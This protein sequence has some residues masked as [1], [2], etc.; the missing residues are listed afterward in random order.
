MH[1]KTVI[2]GI[3]ESEKHKIIQ[4]GSLVQP[5]AQSW[6]NLEKVIAIY[7]ISEQLLL[8]LLRVVEKAWGEKKKRVNLKV[9]RPLECICQNTDNICIFGN[10]YSWQ[11][12]IHFKAIGLDFCR[13]LP[14]E[15]F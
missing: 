9:K 11:R 5:I 14:I 8:V 4:A 1:H 13:S 6:T 10:N 2:L 12:Q 15:I 7:S 3:L